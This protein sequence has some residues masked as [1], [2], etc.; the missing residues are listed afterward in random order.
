[1]TAPQLDSGELEATIQARMRTL[2]SLAGTIA[3]N[4]RA[5]LVP[6]SD[7]PP[8]SGKAALETLRRIRRDPAALRIEERLGAGGMGVVHAGHQ[9]TLDRRV[10]VKTLRGEHLTGDNVESLLGEAW[11]AGSL[12]HP[13]V[14]PIYDLGLDERGAPLLVMKRIEGDTWSALIDDAEAM[15]RHALE[16]DAL[17]FNLRVLIQVCNAVHYAHSRGVVHRDLKP[18]NVM[19]GHFGEVYVV[20]WGVAMRPGPLHHVAGTVVY[21]APEMLGGG[22]DI[23]A[24]TD[25]YLLGAVLCELVTGKPPHDG[26][27]VQAMI[28]SVVVSEPA[29]GD[30][31]EEL[32]AL[33]RACMQRDPA[34]RPE[35]ALEVR[36]ALELFL[37]HRGATAL[38]AQA[39]DKLGE[40]EKLLATAEIE[41][42]HA[43]NVFGECVFGFRQA[44]RG[45]PESEA[46]R[47]GLRRAISTMVRYEAEHGDVRAA[48]RLLGDLEAPDPE[49]DA[50]VEVA[51]R[52]AD[53]EA[54]K[55]E[56]LRTL[57]KELDPREGR[58][59]RLLAGVGFML[60]WAVV[61]AIAPH[62][63]ARY[64]DA[65][66][67]A[68]IP[69]CLL[70]LAMIGVARRLW[71]ETSRINRQL[72]GMFAFGLAVQPLAM[73]ALRY[74]LHADPSF[75]VLALMAYWTLGTGYM[76]VST[77]PRLAPV[78]VAYAVA[79]VLALRLPEQR[80]V[81]A[82]FA[83][84]VT[85]AT[86]MIIWSRRG[87]EIAIERHQKRRE[88]GSSC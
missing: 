23:T 79:F 82:T 22:G 64:P 31:P 21:M 88:R 28:A 67:L 77:E 78:P 47:A 53:A 45:W 85:I 73:A 70:M 17:E 35:S 15:K 2:S 44:L 48:A 1:V 62:F 38:A 84:V 27:N 87:T 8:H 86:I 25:V 52:R 3:K 83:N 19:I 18:D 5:T 14:V 43:Y 40:L 36:R 46:A 9:V 60:V 72:V 7:T 26:A 20:D 41:V 13:N 55:I 51:R 10:A 59:S 39:E 71:R 63:L 76:A 74:G 24:R 61:P 66:T 12:E 80:Y 65:E 50:L 54:K 4:P 75:T 58:R 68:S 37:E 16:V 56:E 34:M 33:V 49:L 57:E 81:V 11:V 30:A 69:I 42:E 29:L 32:A 6:T